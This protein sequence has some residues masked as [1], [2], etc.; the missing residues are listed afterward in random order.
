MSHRSIGF[1]KHRKKPKLDARSHER[2]LART[3]VDVD[4]ACC[5]AAHRRIPFNVDIFVSNRKP[6]RMVARGRL[7]CVVN[8]YI[9][10]TERSVTRFVGPN[11]C[12]V[13]RWKPGH[14]VMQIVWIA[15][16]HSSSLPSHF[17]CCLK[18]ERMLLSLVS[19]SCAYPIAVLSARR[20]RNI[21]IGV[22]DCIAK[23]T[24]YTPLLTNRT[25][26]VFDP[27]TGADR[28]SAMCRSHGLTILPNN[29]LIVAGASVL[30]AM[31][32]A[33]FF[34]GEN[35]IFRSSSRSLNLAATALT[36]AVIP[37]MVVTFEV[38]IHAFNAVFVYVVQ[39]T[40]V[41]SLSVRLEEGH[42][43]FG[44]VSRTP[45]HSPRTRSRLNKKKTFVV[46]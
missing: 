33:G 13:Y 10:G 18:V 31:A 46:S 8:V 14:S 23:S 6:L 40:S 35:G 29:I 5:Q 21:L 25:S 4:V 15:Y 43:Y 12:V 9:V 7:L 37:A 3:M 2:G 32:S 1:G 16:M 26:P 39:V 19:T 45:R 34:I 44:T 28:A 22:D 42:G 24:S 38:V 30:L 17:R 27:A 11:C 41:W 36:H 20:S